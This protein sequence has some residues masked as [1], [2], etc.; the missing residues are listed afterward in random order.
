MLVASHLLLFYR[1]KRVSPLF[2]VFVAFSIFYLVVGE[3]YRVPADVFP[4]YV[5][6]ESA[7][8]SAYCSALVLC[9][10]LLFANRR[11]ELANIESL[12]DLNIK[13]LRLGY[14]T[15]SCV[16]YTFLFLNYNRFGGIADF[17][18]LGSR[19]D[20]NYLMGET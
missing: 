7:E 2:L 3:L 16:G 14:F 6:Q 15:L 20:R 11:E 17:F 1:T 5:Y 18:N 8:L 10:V 4:R 12:S 9:S 13:F 19:A